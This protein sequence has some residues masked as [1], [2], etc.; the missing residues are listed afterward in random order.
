MRSVGLNVMSSINIFLSAELTGAFL[1]FLCCK[2]QPNVLSL[3]PC[4]G[5]SLL[6]NLRMVPL[7]QLQLWCQA[8]ILQ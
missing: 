6:G 7:V 8:V 3:S 1:T 2:I 4:D 5:I